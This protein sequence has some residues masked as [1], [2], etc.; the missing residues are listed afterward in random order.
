[1]AKKNMGQG[2]GWWAFL[3][4][5]IIAVVTGFSRNPESW[6]WILVVLGLV[7]GHLNISDREA[8]KFLIASV[9]LMLAGSARLEILFPSLGIGSIL[10]NILSSL[11]VLVAPAAIIVGI[12]TVYEAAR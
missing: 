3:I 7:V 10:S 2:L 8:G 12:K 1:M 9:A 5:L 6:A 4:G 11:V